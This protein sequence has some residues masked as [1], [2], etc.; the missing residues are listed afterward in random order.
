MSTLKTALLLSLMMV[1]LYSQS[2]G[3]ATPTTYTLDGQTY[4]YVY[5]TGS[6]NA[7]NL[8]DRSSISSTS[9][10]VEQVYQPPAIAPHPVVITCPYNQIYDNIMCTCVCIHGYYNQNGVCVAI[11]NYGPQCGR[12]EIYRDSR[13]VCA[14][15]FYLIANRCDVCPPYSTY[16][17]AKLQCYCVQGYVAVNG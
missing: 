16:D 5:G 10:N 15:G 7:N 4:S 2:S 17:I 6:A 11:P 9:I 14:A 1:L 3:V 13:C 12:N 8:G